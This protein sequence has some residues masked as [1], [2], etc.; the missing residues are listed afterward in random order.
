MNVGGV[1]E[2]VQGDYALGLP[3]SY[4]KASQQASGKK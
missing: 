4:K 1:H 2:L 3:S